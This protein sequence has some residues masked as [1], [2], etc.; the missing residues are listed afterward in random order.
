MALGLRSLTQD[1]FMPL[2]SVGI[3]EIPGSAGLPFDHGYR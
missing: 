2:A 3:I 1:S